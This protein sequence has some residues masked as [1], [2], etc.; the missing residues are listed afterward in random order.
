M[1]H[2]EYPNSKEMT[3]PEFANLMGAMESDKS[4]MPS[5]ATANV[6][7]TE[8]STDKLEFPRVSD[9][10]K[11]LASLSEFAKLAAP[12]E[13]RTGMAFLLD[14]LG[15][16]PDRIP[17]SN[18]K[19]LPFFADRA[20]QKSVPVALSKRIPDGYECY[21][22]ETVDDADC[23]ICNA[24]WKSYW[25]GNSNQYWLNQAGRPII[26]ALMKAVDER[27]QFFELVLGRKYG[28]FQF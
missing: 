18:V 28:G 17:V 19:I 6:V 4:L 23:S 8:V 14:S 2:D 5:G 24:A 3:L 13:N 11:A 26:G 16:L 9:A 20:A 25:R 27:K 21:Y 15:S 7:D 12:G 22:F 1:Q 10:A